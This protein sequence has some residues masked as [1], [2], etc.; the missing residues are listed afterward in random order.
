MNVKKIKGGICSAVDINTVYCWKTKVLGPIV[1]AN[2]FI[3]F[4]LK[5]LIKNSCTQT[6][7]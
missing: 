7:P 2:F 6:A 1:V 4:Q 5:S 3:S